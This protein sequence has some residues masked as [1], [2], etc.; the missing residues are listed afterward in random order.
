MNLKKKAFCQAKKA[1]Y[2]ENNMSKLQTDFNNLDIER[3]SQP[4]HEAMN[5]GIMG[6]LMGR[7]L[8]GVGHGS[9][10]RKIFKMV[11]KVGK[12][13]EGFYKLGFK[14]GANIQSSDSDSD[15]GKK[16]KHEHKFNGKMEK[17]QRHAQKLANLVEN[18]DKKDQKWETR[19]GLEG[20]HK[21]HVF[22]EL[23][24]QFPDLLPPRIAKFIKKNP[25]MTKDE[26]SQWISE[27]LL[28][29]AQESKNS[30]FE[31]NGILA[32]KF[33][34]MREVFPRM[35][36]RKLQKTILKNQEASPEVLV[37]KIAEKVGRHP[38]FGQRFQNEAFSQ[39]F[40][41]HRR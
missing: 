10:R 3:D 18:G 5:L 16:N 39:H 21:M 17:L 28:K 41:P 1:K 8:G 29:E 9:H 11:K 32:A 25:E 22:R 20:P 37:N 27:K 31:N 36:E 13:F 14:T 23:R 34:Q 19:F 40:N 26:L 35:P 33:A 30:D 2:M 24:S 15:S 4:E 38:F 7:S 6:Q 12:F